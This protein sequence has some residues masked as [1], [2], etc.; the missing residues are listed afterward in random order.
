MNKHEPSD[1]IRYRDVFEASGVAIVILNME[2]D[3]LEVNPSA[4]ELYGYSKD[5]MLAL[6]PKDLVHPDDYEQFDQFV[7]RI[8]HEM[9]LRAK[10]RNLHKDGTLLDV[11]FRLTT[12]EH[13]GQKYLLSIVQDITE[14]VK[15]E[16]KLQQSEE[17]FRAVVENS[18][19]GI[20]IVGE[21]YKF[22]YVNDILCDILGRPQEEILGHD[23]RKFLDEYSQKLVGERY[24]KRQRGEKVPPR[25][26][27]NILRKN[28]ELR[29]V[30][31]S[32]ALVEDPEGR[33]RTIA[34][35]MDI[36]E[37]KEAE[38]ALQVS[39]ER[40]R[41][42]FNTMPVAIWEEDFSAVE[43]AL[44]DLESEGVQDLR[45]YLDGHPEFIDQVVQMI[46]IKDVNAHTLK[47][48]GAETKEELLGSLDKV[49]IPETREILRDELLAIHQRKNYFEGET[50]NCNL[51]GEKLH[52]LL[53]MTIPSE[54]KKLNSV[55]VSM[56][57][58]T[59]RK[60][61][62]QALKKN[63]SKYRTLF[64]RAEQRLKR[65]QA[66]RQV[67]QT[68]SGSL[69]L[70]TTL[71]VLVDQLIQNLE[72]D[73][74]AILLYRPALHTLEYVTGSGFRSEALR[75]TNLR[76]GEGKAGRAV[77][78]RRIIHIPDL[79]L[80]TV[81]FER[82]KLIRQEEFVAYFGVPLIAKGEIVGVLEVFHRNPLDPSPEWVDFL[83]TLAGQA[84]IAIDRLNLF[85]DLER[86]N[87][88]LIRAYNEVI[89]GWA[90]AL[91]LRDQETEGH[92]RRVEELT[93]AI[94]REMGID[95]E[96]LAHVRQGA[97]LHDIGKMGVPD[98]ILQKPGKLTEEEWEVMKKHPTFAYEL[99]SP[100]DHLKPA[101]DI[102]YCHH[103]KWDGSGYPQGL[104]GEEIPLPARIFAV[105][106]VWDALRSDRPYREAWSDE[107]ALRYI[108]DQSGK[109]F[110][111]RVVRIFLDIVQEAG[112][113]SR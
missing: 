111:P 60:R 43:A 10:S 90:R 82:A 98:K 54:K 33:I 85:N 57:D 5:E 2:G 107:D 97:L 88:D 36:T 3:I 67:D 109:H 112:V 102:P 39:E 53:T 91:E 100:I 44:R 17:R 84:A 73:A 108:K 45:A 58:I 104:E 66:L 83:E 95:E 79:T 4:C 62:E 71:N 81:R 11:E 96:E 110:D 24:I 20:L 23:F 55:L 50:V 69:D 41:T 1:E 76:I 52:V 7:A 105:V 34:Q 72:V 47:M 68:I 63:E 65:L 15:A 42:I 78:E 14:R 49:F 89:E 75:Q 29:M 93:L 16:E 106:D 21:D 70:Q 77:L 27:F 64:N 30:E 6:R 80:E 25:Y 113:S 56:M 92:S 59:E 26:E 74:G 87:I 101:L 35:I 103:E 40:Y 9:D 18:H 22:E 32:S 86:S 61:T 48:F 31:I 94:A 19:N 38:K 13:Q 46:E 12:F 51:K 8:P 99:L 28:G 37:R